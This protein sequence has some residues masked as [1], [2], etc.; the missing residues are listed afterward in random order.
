MIRLIQEFI[1]FSIKKFRGEINMN[2]TLNIIK[3]RR[4]IRSYLPDQIKEN[5]LQAILEAGYYAPSARNQ[6]PWHFTVVQNKDLI[7]RL[8]NSFKEF[9]RNTQDEYLQKR[10]NEPDYNVFHHAPTVIIISGDKSNQSAAVDCAAA[11]QNMMIQA[12]SL[13]IGS[14]WIGLIAHLLNSD[15]GKGYLKQLLIPDG[16]KQ[17]HAITLGYKASAAPSAPKRKQNIISYIR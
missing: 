4:S 6:Q 7:D 3:A 11:V 12:E 8:N 13:G 16:Y 10:G 2:E 9:A 17:I 15:A 14:C 5:E 1:V